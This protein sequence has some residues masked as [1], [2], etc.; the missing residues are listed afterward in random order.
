MERSHLN[1]LREKSNI[2]VLVETGHTSKMPK[3]LKLVTLT[4]FRTRSSTLVMNG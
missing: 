1:V 3:S 2:E 4:A